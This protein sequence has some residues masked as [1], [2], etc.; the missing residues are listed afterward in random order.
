MSKYRNVR[1]LYKGML[2]DSLKELR[3]YQELELNQQAGIIS[4]L[5]RQVSFNLDVNRQRVCIYKADF[6]YMEN[7]KEVIED[8]KGMRTDVYRLKK[9]LMK[10]VHGIEILET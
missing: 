1:S 7:G 6:V 5:R 10:A 8:A 9:K 2:F 3:R 4:N